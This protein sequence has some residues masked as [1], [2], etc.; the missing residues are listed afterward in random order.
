MARY[1][2][3]KENTDTT[4]KVVLLFLL[5][6]MLSG[7]MFWAVSSLRKITQMDYGIPDSPRH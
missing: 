6:I 5:S 1:L 4:K 7:V 2:Q 3:K